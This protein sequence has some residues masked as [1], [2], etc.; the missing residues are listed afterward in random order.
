MGRDV[1]SMVPGQVGANMGVN[2]PSP[3]QFSPRLPG[4]DISRQ[5]LHVLQTSHDYQVAT[6]HL[7]P[8]IPQPNVNGA[9]ILNT[10]MSNIKISQFFRG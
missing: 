6:S 4:N 10:P 5:E 9:S 7:N 1:H 8:T 2:M 3:T